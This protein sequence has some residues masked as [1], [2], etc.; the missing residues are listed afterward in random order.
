LKI[1]IPRA[2]SPNNRKE[3][4]DVS[5][6]MGEIISEKI[7]DLPVPFLAINHSFK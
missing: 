2:K 5:D 4:D 7:P 3:E 1:R 6:S